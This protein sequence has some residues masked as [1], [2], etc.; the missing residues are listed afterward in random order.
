MRKLVKN[1][2][3]SYST[4]RTETVEVDGKWYNIPTMYGGKSVSSEEALKR[5]I[6]NKMTDEE[7]GRSFTPHND[8]DS[9][10]KAARERSKSLTKKYKLKKR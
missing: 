9:A 7:T 10:V 3:G 6:K 2:D 4:E 1:K 8:V 5:A